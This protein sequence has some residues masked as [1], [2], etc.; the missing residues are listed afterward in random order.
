VLILDTGELPAVRRRAR[1]RADA[2]GVTPNA[3]GRIASGVLLDA[4]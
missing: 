3:A 2:A 4:L 1:S